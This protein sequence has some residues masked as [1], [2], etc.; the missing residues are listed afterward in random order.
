VKEIEKL[1]AV[2]VDFAKKLALEHTQ[3]NTKILVME[4]DVGLKKGINDAANA[5]GKANTI[6]TACFLTKDD[7]TVYINCIVPSSLTDKIKAGEWANTVAAV[8][9]GKGGGKPTFAAGQGDGVNKFGEALEVA[10]K[11]VKEK[12]G[13][14]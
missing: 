9:K 4:L 2:T 1:V 11:F 14:K 10:S 8:C 5:F 13:D 7:D 3:A 12:L 6:T